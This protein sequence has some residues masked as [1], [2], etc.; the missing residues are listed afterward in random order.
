[1]AA[2]AFTTILFD[3]SDGVATLTLNR[4]DR[5]NS[6]NTVM[7]GEVK[8][9]LD[10]VEADDS[11][12]VLVLTGTGRGFCAGQDLSDRAVKPGAERVDLGASIENYYNPLIRRLKALPMPVICGVNGVAAGAGANIALACDIVIAAEGA[13]FIQPFCNI[14]LL[15]DSGGTYVLPRLVGVARAT[16]L[17][18]LGDKLPAKTAVEWGLIW[19]AVPDEELAPTVQKLAA[20]LATAPTRGLATIKKALQTSLSNTLDEQLDLE[21]DLQ[22]EMGYMEDYQEGVSAFLEKR[23]PTFKGR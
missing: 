19:Q 7:H 8:S 13:S 23:K 9:A 1:M 16:A 4:P 2:T 17:A 21:R 11:V 18:M 15:P 3:I 12:R 5:M 20:R 10:A 14:G 6:F 22:R